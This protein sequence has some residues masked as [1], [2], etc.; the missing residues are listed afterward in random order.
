MKKSIVLAWRF[1][2]LVNTFNDQLGVTT[3]VHIYTVILSDFIVWTFNIKYTNYAIFSFYWSQSW[4][5]RKCKYGR[6]VS[7]CIVCSRVLSMDYI[8]PSWT[9]FWCLLRLLFRLPSYSQWGHGYLLPS[10][11]DCWCIMRFVLNVPT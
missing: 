2:F 7:W 10:W 3:V 1:L 11:T 5:E 8:L 6:L 9:D 4:H